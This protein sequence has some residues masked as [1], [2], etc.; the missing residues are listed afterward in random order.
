MFDEASSW[1]SPQKIELPE[2]HGLEEISEDNKESEEQA[3]DPSEERE[4][5]SLK[6]KSS[7]KTVVYQPTFKELRPSQM[8]LGKLREEMLGALNEATGKCS[9]QC[10]T[11]SNTLSSEILILKAENKALRE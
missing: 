2:S 7:L 8:K 11:S 4:S 10:E 3:S 6:D 5:S 9:H 1:W